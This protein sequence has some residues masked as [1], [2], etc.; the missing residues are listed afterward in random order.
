M[1]H[2]A[3][4]PSDAI[5]TVIA[6][7]KARDFVGV[8]T[9]DAAIEIAGCGNA[10]RGDDTPGP[11]GDAPIEELRSENEAVAAAEG[12]ESEMSGFGATGDENTPEAIPPIV[13]SIVF[14]VI[15]KWLE[16]RRNR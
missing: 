9:V 2:T 6:G 5:Q 13:F 11:F 14:F 15:Q 12:A 1:F 16:R 8:E 4:F 7:V 10:F 3:R